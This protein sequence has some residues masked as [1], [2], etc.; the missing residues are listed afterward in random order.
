MIDVMECHNFSRWRASSVATGLVAVAFLAAAGVSHAAGGPDD[1]LVNTSDSQLA[2][3][4]NA[5]AANEATDGLAA[6]AG[7]LEGVGG[8]RLAGLELSDSGRRIVAH[9]VGSTPPV[10]ADY[11][12]T[13]PDG[14]HVTNVEG[15]RYGRAHLQAVAARVADTPEAEAVGVSSITVKSDGSGL[16]VDLVSGLPADAVRAAL[17]AATGLPKSAVEFVPDTGEIIRLPAQIKPA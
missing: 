15:A 5:D 7:Q 11:V 12:A 14:V 13:L 6:V 9:W 4:L 2:G 17:V 1:R 16:R 8:E 3:I 10:V